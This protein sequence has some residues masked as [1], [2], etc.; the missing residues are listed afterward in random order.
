MLISMRLVA[1]IFALALLPSAPAVAAT[2]VTD[3]GIRDLRLGMTAQQA[4]D[5]GWIKKSPTPC[6][7][8]WQAARYPKSLFVG[9]WNDQVMLIS[10]SSRRFV[11]QKGIRP[12]DSVKKLK[13]RYPVS[14]QSRNIY[15]GAPIYGSPDGSLYFPT[16]KGKVD[17]LELANGFVPNGSEYEC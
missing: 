17:V 14:K 1:G 5:L 3:S 4:A 6:N 2:T 8:G 9:V 7:G 12:G 15:T 10:V 16:G 11:T 13:A